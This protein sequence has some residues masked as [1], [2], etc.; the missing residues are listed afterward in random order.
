LAAAARRRVLEEDPDAMAAWLS[1]TEAARRQLAA[2]PDE[3]VAGAIRRALAA[4]APSP[5]APSPAALSNPVLGG[6]WEDGARPGEGA[7]GG[8]S[9]ALEARE[10]VLEGLVAARDI[11]GPAQ[12]T[13]R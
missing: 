3:R 12:M 7:A 2:A 10:V 13:T 9:G 11:E 8:A 1:E 5:T 4:L 6:A